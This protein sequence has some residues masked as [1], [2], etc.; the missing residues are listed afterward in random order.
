MKRTYIALLLI[1]VSANI[2]FAQVKNSITKAKITFEIKNLGFK[3]GGTIGG[4]QGS[5]AFDPANLNTSTIEAT[6]DANTLNTDNDLRDEHIK[7]ESYFN[8]AAYPKITMSSTAFKHK[9]GS[10]YTG[11]FNVSI[12]GIT[13]PVEVP[14]SYTVTGSSAQLKG[15]FKIKRSDFGIGGSGMTL[16]D[17]ATIFIDAEAAK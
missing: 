16:S 8:V 9:G 15:S 10:N 17:D 4:V 6:A 11:T 7:G 12:K 2:A 3:T 1:I 5:I 14:F 13:K